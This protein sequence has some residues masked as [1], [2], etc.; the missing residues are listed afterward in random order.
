MPH[1]LIVSNVRSGSTWLQTMLAALPDVGS[2]FEVKWRPSYPTS[3]VHLILDSAANL[4]AA[5]D[6]LGGGRPIAGS[7]LVL[8]ALPLSDPQALTAAIP[9]GTRIVHLTRTYRSAFLS[10][11]RGVRHLRNPDGY[12]LNSPAIACHVDDALPL[13]LMQPHGQPVSPGNCHRVL[14]YFLENDLWAST[15]R[16]RSD[17]SYMLVDYDDVGS[18]FEHIVRF[19]ESRAAPD[20]IGRVLARPPLQRLPADAPHERVGNLD[21]LE[22][23]FKSY[24]TLRHMLVL[25]GVNGCR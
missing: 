21:G 18:S 2:D 11:L 20:L 5:L 3:P 23:I 25:D 16:Q 19:I 15:L 1:F 9:A 6:L 13:E 14:S 10:L 7:K 22:P 4:A 24:E 17:L 12:A 8:D